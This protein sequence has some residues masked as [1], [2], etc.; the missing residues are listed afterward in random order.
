MSRTRRPVRRDRRGVAAVEFALATPLVFLATFLIAD[1]VQL[2]RGWMRVQSVAMQIGQIVSQC[3]VFHTADDA[4]LSDIAKDLLGKYAEGTEQ[5]RLI[6]NAFG[7]DD[8]DG[9][10]INFEWKVDKGSTPALTVTSK[11]KELPKAPAEG[12]TPETAFVMGKNKMLF[13]TEVYA[14][15]DRT[16]LTR[17]VNV[18]TANNR[19]PLE[20]EIGRGEALHSTRYPTTEKL[21]AKKTS[22]ADKGCL[23]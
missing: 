15:L 17:G 12:S 14:R 4:V 9:T 20:F 18:L 19:V 22:D 13:R 8:K 7:R 6:V 2:C 23:K 1:V 10:G 21:K 11:G 16:F 5:W 3:E